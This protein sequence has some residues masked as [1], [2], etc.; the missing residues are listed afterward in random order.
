MRR[1]HNYTFLAEK[2]HKLIQEREI[3]FE[4]IISSIEE[5]Y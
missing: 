3:S 2:N 5:G 4:E 1:H